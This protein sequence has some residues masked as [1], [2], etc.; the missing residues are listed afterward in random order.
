MK[1][2]PT[3]RGAGNMSSLFKTLCRVIDRH[4]KTGWAIKGQT[5]LMAALRYRCSG[6]F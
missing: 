2:F 4:K 3:A 6:H 1:S 5:M